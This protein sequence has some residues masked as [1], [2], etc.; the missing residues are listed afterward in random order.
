MTKKELEVMYF[1]ISDHEGFPVDKEGNP[2]FD[3]A[4]QRQKRFF[5]SGVTLNPA[6]RVCALKALYNAVKDAEGEINEALKADLGKSAF[7]SYMCEVGMT[8]SEISYMIGHVRRFSKRKRVKTPLAQ[9]ASKS[10]IQKSP[11]GTVLIMTPWNYPFMLAMEPLAGRARRGKYRDRQ[12]L[13]VFPQRFPRFERLDRAHLSLRICHR[14]DG[15]ESGKRQTFG[16]E[17]R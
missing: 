4:L 2:D 3:G 13:R 15:R 16:N 8:L 11:Y 6:Y 1:K 9:F 10:F 5:Q 17:I 14:G 12:A 7:E